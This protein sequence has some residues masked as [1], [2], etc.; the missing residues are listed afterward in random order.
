[1]VFLCTKIKLAKTG[2][3]EFLLFYQ[4]CFSQ[5]NMWAQF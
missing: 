5:M 3:L 4:I 2:D 1:M